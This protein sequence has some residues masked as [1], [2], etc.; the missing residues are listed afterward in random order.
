[1][2]V[3]GWLVLIG[4]AANPGSPL[5]AVRFQPEPSPR[6]SLGQRKPDSLSTPPPERKKVYFILVI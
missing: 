2:L 4:G 6:W 5:W 3:M 1:V